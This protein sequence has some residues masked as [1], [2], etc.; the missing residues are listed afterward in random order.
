MK[1]LLPGED[2][3]HHKSGR[4]MPAQVAVHVRTAL[5]AVA[6]EYA[7]VFLHLPETTAAPGAQRRELVGAGGIRHSAG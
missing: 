7:E 6:T 1:N 2:Y 5:R 3:R 4:Q